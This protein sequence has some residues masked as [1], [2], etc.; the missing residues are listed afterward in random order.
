MLMIS[1]LA[2]III[3]RPFDYYFRRLYVDFVI[4]KTTQVVIYIAAIEQ[5]WRC[6]PDK[7]C[8]IG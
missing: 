2:V 1:W 3:I 8:A 4:L 7:Q 5:R 6:C